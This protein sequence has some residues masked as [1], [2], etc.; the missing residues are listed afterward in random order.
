MIHRDFCDPSKTKHYSGLRIQFHFLLSRFVCRNGFIPLTVKEMAQELK[1]DVQSIHKF[2]RQG[3]REGL[4]TLDGENLFLEQRVNDHNKGYVK[5]YPVLESNQF[6]ALSLHAQRFVL[7]A[8]WY[9][10]ASGFRRWSRI[11]SLYH[12]SAFERN[13]IL[14]IYHR[15]PIYKVLEEAQQ[16]L[17]IDFKTVQGEEHFLIRGLKPQYANENALENQGEMKLLENILFESGC[18]D[19]LSEE[20]KRAILKLKSEY[21]NKYDSIGMELFTHALDN[22]LLSF[23][24]VSLEQQGTDKVTKYLRG[25]LEDLEAKIL[26]TLQ[27]RVEYL[28]CAIFH[29]KDFIVNGASSL[30]TSFEKQMDKLQS[31]CSQISLKKQN[32]AQEKPLESFPFYNWLENV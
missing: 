24:L 31:I 21:I 12:S 22:I 11:T 19:L 8:L 23:K 13:G 1:C 6:K 20:T 9:V 4:L 29:T 17:I 27:K 28:K 2:I 16:I 30:V 5:H 10:G 3:V 25:I 7:Y 18:F 26:P 15:A 14:N 32:S